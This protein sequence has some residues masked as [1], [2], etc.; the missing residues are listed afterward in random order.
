[1]GEKVVVQTAVETI[2]AYATRHEQQSSSNQV[3]ERKQHS[4]GKSALRAQGRINLPTRVH[5]WL[6]KVSGCGSMK[7]SALFYSKVVKRIQRR[8]CFFMSKLDYRGTST[9][10]R[11][12]GS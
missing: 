1:M 9:H 12:R 2:D 11:R 7:L 4:V 8:K 6:S 5:C 3:R 10:S